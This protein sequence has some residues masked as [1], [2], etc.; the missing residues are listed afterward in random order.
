M[1]STT[2]N[3]KKLARTDVSKEMWV[4]IS[5]GLNHYE[6]CLDFLVTFSFFY[7]LFNPFYVNLHRCLLNRRAIALLLC[8][9]YVISDI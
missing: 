7:G 5:K 4:P 1:F 9:C 3:L 6:V 8:F 2:K